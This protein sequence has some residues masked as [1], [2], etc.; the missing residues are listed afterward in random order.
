MKA[1]VVSGP[2]TVGLVDRDA[3]TAAADEIVVRPVLVGLC[4]TDLEIIEGTIDPAYVRLP[5]T[6]GHEWA[7]VVTDSPAGSPP[8]GA[9]VVVEG[10]VPCGECAQC[11]TGDTNRCRIYDEIGFTR[12]G[13]AAEQIVVP[14]RLAHVLADTVSFASGALVEPAAVVYRALDRV[15][16]RAGARVL[17]IG[18]GTVGLLAAYLVRRWEPSVVDVLGARAAQAGLAAA[19]GA[20]RFWTDPTAVTGGYD[21]VVE[22]AG[23]PAAAETAF[24]AAARGAT[25]ALLGLAGTGESARL[26]LDDIVNGDIE[27]VGSFS[28]TVRAWASV[29]DLLNAGR[30]S[31]DFLVTHRFDLADWRSAI[32]TVRDCDGARG[33]VLLRI[34]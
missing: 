7:G 32:V 4:G 14:A 3:A 26:P 30:V 34:S 31:F 1:L 33:K 15:A 13:A 22:A 24:A 18:D 19:A 16:P 10:I 12:H 28:Y 9:R 5:V 29:V 2:G 11:A 21:V 17:V 6:L 23:V 27:I 25:I 8:V 20:D